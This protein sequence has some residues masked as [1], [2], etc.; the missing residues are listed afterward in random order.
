M[1]MHRPQQGF[2]SITLLQKLTPPPRPFQNPGSAPDNLYDWNNP[3]ATYF[4]TTDIFLA[5]VIVVVVVV[6]LASAAN[7]HSQNILILASELPIRGGIYEGVDSTTQIN[8]ER[9]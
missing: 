3:K 6:V 9:V 1:L 2:G 4:R 8:Q 5:V 7:N